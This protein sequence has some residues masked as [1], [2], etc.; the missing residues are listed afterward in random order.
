M[1]S[2]A[3]VAKTFPFVSIASESGG[4]PVEV[5]LIARLGTGA[6]NQVCTD[7]G[8]RQ[9]QHSS[10]I[11]E[12]DE[13]SAKLGGSHF[14]KGDPT[15]LYS[16]VVGPQGHPFHRHA[17]HRIF[18]AV[19]GG[20]GAQLRFSSASDQQILAKLCSGNALRQHPGRLHFYSAL[21]RPYMAPVCALGAQH[22]ASGVVCIVLSHQRDGW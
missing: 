18:T 10:F 14:S 11:D 5:S 13:P 22:S 15:A 16:F 20:S 9:Q 12:M 17:G 21:W 19:S 4:V 8:A 3:G 7:V 2:I 1:V 6:G